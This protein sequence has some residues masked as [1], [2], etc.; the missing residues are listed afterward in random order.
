MLDKAGTLHTWD[1]LANDACPLHSDSLDAISV[2]VAAGGRDSTIAVGLRSGAVQMYRLDQRFAKA[3][4]Q[5]LTRTQEW[6]ER[7]IL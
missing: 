3:S 7:A 1:L 4:E 5:E 6:L 2:S